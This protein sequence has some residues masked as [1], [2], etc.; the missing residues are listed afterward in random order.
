MSES[1]E[2]NTLLKRDGTSRQQRLLEALLPG[3]AAID[4]RGIAD[5]IEFAEAFSKELKFYSDS[6]SDTNASWEGFMSPENDKDLNLFLERLSDDDSAFAAYAQK[7]EGYTQPQKALFLAFLRLF[8]IAQDDLNKIGKKHIDFYYRDVLKMKELPPVADKVHLIFE[9]AKHVR[10]SHRIEEGTELKAGKDESGQPLTYAT[11]R[12]LVANHGKVAGLKAVY[13][14]KRGDDRL[15]AS[16]VVNSSDGAGGEIETEEKSWQAFGTVNSP[17]AEMGCAI[18]SPMLRLPEGNRKVIFSFLFDSSNRNDLER[19][20]RMGG[21]HPG[22]LFRVQFSGEEGWIETAPKDLAADPETEKEIEKKALD[23]INSATVHDINVKIKDDPSRGYSGDRPGYTI[24]HIV[25]RRIVEYRTENMKG[26]YSKLDQVLKVRGLGEDKLAD[27]R[28]TFTKKLNRVKIN[29]AEGS[30]TIARTLDES[31][32]PVTTYNR[33]V[34]SDPIET[35]WPVAKIILNMDAQTPGNFPYEHLKNLKLREVKVSVDVEGVRNNI[36]QNDAGL[37]DPGSPFMPFGNRPGTGSSFYIGNSELLQKKPDKLWINFDWQN[38]PDESFD[39]YYKEYGSELEFSTEQF[40]ASLSILQ[41]R[42][43]AELHS[44]LPLFMTEGD[45]ERALGSRSIALTETELAPLRRNPFMEENTSYGTSTKDGFLRLVLGNQDFGHK[46]Y[47]RVYSFNVINEVKYP[48]GSPSEIVGKIKI[49][50]EPYTPVISGLS[51]DYKASVILGRKETE[52]AG[53]DRFFLVYPF[54]V[55][56]SASD[57]EL[58]GL[59]PAIDDEGSLFIG[60][61]D[62]SGGQTISLLI[63]VAEGSADPDYPRQPVYWSFLSGDSWIP[64]NDRQILADTTNELLASGIISFS[65][66]KSATTQH[67]LLPDGLVWFR[68][69]A[70]KQTPAISSLISIEAQAVTAQFRDKNNDPGHLAAPLPADTIA[71]LKTS[72][73]AIKG[74]M[75]PFSSFGGSVKEKSEA[76]YVR[77]SERLRHKQRAITIWDYERLILQNFPSV[78]KVKCLNHIRFEG[79]SGTYSEIAPGYVSLIVVSDVKNRN[80]VEPLKPKTSLTVLSEIEDFIREIRAEAVKVRVR[81][82]L[83]E[84]IKVSF[85]VSFHEGMDQGFYSE[86]LN[87]EI[88]SYLSP[89]AFQETPEVVFGGRIHKSMILHFV[90][91]RPYVDFVTCFRMDH[92]IPE[93]GGSGMKVLKDIDEAEATTAASVLGS[94]P[95]HNITVLEDPECDCEDNKVEAFKELK[96]DDC[97]CN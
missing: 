32:P 70:A 1:C 34:L 79:V 95:Q 83:Y 51:I 68:A 30:I 97:G 69:S 28:Y 33:E 21:S 15:Y 81:N 36:L 6:N 45:G 17:H 20:A 91:K 18:A 27:I 8:K 26:A 7:K 37:L 63:Q 94:A 14:D 74:V 77:V 76:F 57:S 16:P 71:K 80:A 47:A 22:N 84:E 93:G 43:W 5:L 53:T 78:Y 29:P 56:S 12:E 65:V 58:P 92:R 48:A 60:V 40:L 23:F 24:G 49:P 25:S 59:V 35:V 62:F 73:S 13:R 39:D 46:D 3:Y 96:T 67:T 75:Q 55:T 52:H 66:P 89:W 90:E 87:R 54:G 88:T 38:L 2:N 64:F 82:P 72:D 9:L 19:I 4:E 10:R 31:D 44:G 61:R 11:L 41:G 42:R 86:V 85:K 50:N